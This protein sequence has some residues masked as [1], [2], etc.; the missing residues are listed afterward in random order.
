MKDS[1]KR[2]QRQA[3]LHF[4]ERENQRSLAGGKSNS[5]ATLKKKIF[6]ILALLCAVAQGT[7]ADDGWSSASSYEASDEPTHYD[8]YG[9]RSDVHVIKTAA[10]YLYVMD[11]PAYYCNKNIYLDINVDVSS[12]TWI[13]LDNIL[14]V[15]RYLESGGS[16]YRGTF[17]GNGHTIRIN[18]DYESY[19][20]YKGP[21]GVI[22]KGGKVQDL[23][24]EGTIYLKK[25]DDGN[26]TDL[27][28]GICGE[29]NG[30]IENCSVSASVSSEENYL[31]GIT[32]RNKGTISN[33]R[34]S[35][36]VSSDSRLVGGIAG[37]NNGT[38]SNC[39]VSGNVSSDWKDSGVAATA[40]VG[41]IAG[42]NNGTIEYCCMT[43]NVTNNDADV[44][45]LVGDNDHSGATVRHCTFYG[46]RNSTHDQ[47]SIYVGDSGTEEYL[48]GIFSL[49]EYNA[50]SG[51]DMYRHAIRYTYA[52]NVTTVGP[53]TIRTWAADEYDVTRTY[54]NATFSL[55]VTSGTMA[56]YTLTD[57]DGNNIDLQGHANDWS[58]FWFVMPKKNVTATVYFYADWPTQGAGTAESPY[59]IGSAD[60]W[61]KFANNVSCGR[62]YSGSHVK[63]TA[64]ISVTTMAGGTFSGTFDGDGH[65]IT[66]NISGTGSMALFN[67]LN[68]GTIKNLTV[69][70][71]ISG[72]QH[73]AALL[74]SLG[75]DG[76][77]LVENCVITANVN[78]SE[79]HM[80]GFL[81]H[82]NESNITFRG[83]V[84]KGKM[85][86]GSTAKGV[87]YGW[88][89]N[90][91]SGT[92]S[93]TDC[94]Y[95]MADGQDTDG[96]DL[97]ITESNGTFAVT[98]CYKTASAGSQGTQV[99]S[100]SG[101]TGV[102]V[103]NAGVAGSTYNVS[104]LTFCN[105]GLQCGD[106]AYA[107]NGNTVSLTIGSKSGYTTSGYTASAG[108]LS[109]T[110][111]PYT[112]TMPGSNV[113]ISASECSANALTPDGS[114]NYLINSVDDWNTFCAQIERGT[115]T[116]S[117]KTVK[118]TDDISVE[119]MAGVWSDTQSERRVF[120]GTFDGD[121]HTLTINVG[122]QSRFAA[123]FKCVSGA[124]IKKL[125]TAGTINGGNNSDGK[126]LAG[127]VG[128]SFGNNT[129]TGCR[130]HVTL[131]TNFGEDA[132]MAGFVAGTKGGSLT[133]S[134]CV[135]DG[136]MKGSS[137]THCAGIA[138]FEYAATTTTISNTLFAP[139]TLTVS[140]TDDGNT[141]TFSRDP[142]ATDFPNCYY[143]QVLGAAQGS[144]A[145]YSASAPSALG[146]LVQD[147]GVVKAYDNGLFFDGKYYFAPST[148]AGTGTEGDP[149]IISNADQWETFV[150]DVNTNGNNYNGKYIL[151]AADL[152]VTT[153]MGTSETNSFQGTF[154]G[155][156]HTLTFTKGTSGSAF[157][158]EYCAPF[159][160]TN[161]AT[162]KDLKTAGDI[163]TSN[164]FATGLIGHS[165]GTT[166][167]TNCHVSTNIYSSTV[168]GYNNHDGTHG[169]FVAM[170][171]GTLNI[172]GCA[173]TGRLL[174]NNGTTNCG[175]FVAWHNANTITVANSLYAPNS[176]IPTGWSAITSGA[177]FVRGNNEIITNCYY[178]ETLG[179]AQG[180]K[181]YTLATAPANLG[182]LEQDYGM[183]KA[184]Q[185]GI[186][187]DGLYYAVLNLSGAG[188]EADPYIIGTADQWNDFANYVTN[189]Y[190]FSGKFVKLTDNINVSTMAGG[191]EDY[192]FQGTFDGDGHTLT[193]SY[194][195]SA[196]STAPFRFA[197]NAIIN[198]LHVDGTIAT[199]AKFAG[200]IVGRSS[201]TL[202]I[203][204][205][206]S[207]VAIN[208]SVGGDGTHGGIVARIAGGGNTIIID[209]CVFDGSFATT[210]G[211][212]NCGGFVGWPVTD[213]PVI[214]NSLMK[215]SSVA[216][217]MLNNTFARWYYEPTITN[218]Y[219]VTT[220]NL[221]TNQGAQ[222]VAYAT[223]PANLGSLVPGY[224][225]MTI[226]ENGIL[227]DGTYYMAPA[228]SLADNADNSSTISSNNGKV[229]DVTLA[230]RTL[231]KNGNWNT[232]C[233]PF[234]VTL[235]GSPL[236]GA[237]ARPLSAGSIDGSTLN[238][239]FGVAVDELVAGTPYIIKWPAAVSFTC[240]ATSGTGTGDGGYDKLVDGNTNTKW[241]QNN[242]PW[243]CEF[244]TSVPVGV[245]GYTLTTGGDTYTYQD[246]NPLKWT[247]EAKV[248]SSDE[249][250]VIDIRDV[251]AN[252]G[253]ALPVTNTTE[254][255]VYA[256]A[257]ERWGTY[258][259]F[260]FTVSQSGG[261]LMQLSELTLQQDSDIVNPVF[262]YVTIDETN[263]SYDN[264]ASGDQ[265]VRFLGMYNST[266]FTASDQNSFLLIDGNNTVYYPEVDASIGA[267]RAYFKI[268][269]DDPA[270]ASQLS[271]FNLIFIGESAGVISRIVEGYGDE[272]GK[273][274]FIAS[275]VNSDI[276]P[277]AVTNL[278][279]TY[280]SGTGLYDYDLF[281]LNPGESQ[282]ENYVTHTGD[283]NIVN[284]NGYL[285]ATQTTKNLVFSGIFN[286]ENSKTVALSDGFNLVG[287]PFG[288]DAYVSKP[289]YQMNDTGT[290]IEPIDNYDTYTPVT[291]PPCTGIVVRASGADEVT[292]STSAP[293]QQSSGNNGNIQMTL[294][295]AGV[296]SDAFQDKAI[297]SF[298]EG[299]QI[300]KFVF[301][302]RHAK[303]YIPQYGEDYAIAFSDMNGEVPL[304]F[305][306]KETG[307]YTIGFNFENVKG[308]R[309]QLIDKIEDNIIDLNANDSYTFMGSSADSDDRFTLVFTQVEIDGIFA[310][311]SGNDIIVS[312]NGELQV[313]DVM[314][315]MVMTQH[316]NGVETV[317]KPEQ[318]GV[319]IFR[320]NGKSQKIVVR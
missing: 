20:S 191:S 213:R 118:L 222:A 156:N 200:G 1:I 16:G 38:I 135:F 239:T 61:N 52:V 289:F 311:Q 291:I 113:T 263:R 17:Y 194:N 132:A 219:F 14:G 70:G 67:R 28:G 73:T 265:Q 269:A 37:E 218:C 62:P 185:N 155:N 260:R 139:T 146:S 245:T 226:Y 198:N 79:S 203:T 178:T 13:N 81:A 65:T 173:Y 170:P 274:A 99:Y 124:T 96:L 313:F 249:W 125:R 40:K 298:N 163:Y 138:G 286:T 12:K 119:T 109:G 134:G 181:A 165:Y 228:I 25:M 68:G 236:A 98:N 64:D 137:N 193:V 255:Q 141:K 83:C 100:I 120:S 202:N 48:F 231:Y 101:G 276:A 250:T 22:D 180:T 234:D 209:G 54:P 270:P 85:T 235:A 41:G 205:C 53:G 149:Y 153:M 58:S 316:I 238:L 264:G 21:F 312:G 221:P 91:A 211:T 78:C 167:I 217:G 108:T 195:T 215:P 294:T 177:T 233:L 157:N 256:I 82:G 56:R 106:V 306:T 74:V 103:A 80:G 172:E 295:K 208:S 207:S 24:V 19:S 36:N 248:T 33:C 251:T 273:W 300:E 244:N 161:G 206:R 216:A 122:N 86:G 223:A 5:R 314:G 319:Y 97:A 237:T 35:G 142:Q 116:F 169:A 210:N 242:G 189:G 46:T 310:Y 75:N 308:V 261:S 186:L 266:T 4:A 104:G 192:S 115:N 47:A 282:W 283:F 126:L 317:E 121:G 166:T 188:T 241:C 3:G 288:V 18:L 6:L 162:I 230:D 140:T 43:G 15:H 158:E 143:T 258:Q 11:K 184:Y 160:Y 224:S 196:E 318:T 9:G 240:T 253:D 148:S 39:W 287:N 110:G 159:R 112:L 93:I 305:K 57:A 127:L 90:S 212:I 272:D 84:F 71:G 10:N 229:F 31:G 296:R 150:Y 44:G 144:E 179:D 183:L 111:N 152:S 225:M 30:T 89:S 49:D 114:G 214:K 284:G 175:G 171:D 59:I 301:N 87:F 60:D 190:K 145:I 27:V 128:V 77:N 281:R 94:L 182:S 23:N 51:K 45:G 299:S 42:E 151:L 267:Q 95:I 174:T 259:Y 293:Q 88:G 268:G 66:A 303:L 8:T 105:I 154:L 147:Y 107:A 220:A 76:T 197:R 292:F 129:I 133:I 69:A 176:S 117:G 243:T 26:G 304:N 297:V 271:V 246:R 130:S 315:R 50:A 164:K 232:L 227:Y 201:G 72:G 187:Y 29:N 131:T 277:A 7:W 307:R 252:S 309:I 285:Y 102:S 262:N 275:P 254:S 199:S 247:L 168:T 279:G 278:I 123:P 320:L 92:R 136:E 280:D 2:E 63:L 34:V 257:S 302:E 204:N 55:N 32:G 290:D